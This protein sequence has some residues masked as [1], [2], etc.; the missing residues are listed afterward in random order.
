LPVG[1]EG[2]ILIS[3]KILPDVE[4]SGAVGLRRCFATSRPALIAGDNRPLALGGDA[5]PFAVGGDMR[6]LAVGGDTR[7]LEP[8]GGVWRTCSL[9]PS[10]TVGEPVP[11]KGAEFGGTRP[12]NVSESL[13]LWAFKGLDEDWRCWL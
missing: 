4:G 9:L 12:R 7:P 3:L 5:R 2:A 1:W 8:A 11:V 13:R 6:P 10:M